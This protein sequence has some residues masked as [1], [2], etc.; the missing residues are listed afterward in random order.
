MME[1]EKAARALDLTL[2][3]NSDGSYSL[4]PVPE[5]LPGA[6]KLTVGSQVCELVE[7][8]GTLFV[9]LDDLVEPCH[10]RVTR[11]PSLNSIDVSVVSAPIPSAVPEESPGESAAT[12]A[13]TYSNPEI[14]WS[15][16]VPNGWLLVDN[17]A[18]LD[19][20]MAMGTEAVATQAGKQ[21][22]KASRVGLQMVMVKTTQTS[23]SLS[24]AT[25]AL[26]SSDLDSRT[27][28][29]LARKNLPA[30]IKDVKV[31][32]GPIP[33]RVIDGVEFAVVEYQM[34]VEAVTKRMRVLCCVDPGRQ[35]GYV[36]TLSG[37]SDME[38]RETEKVLSGVRVA[39]KA[40]VSLAD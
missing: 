3:K 29:E 8:N 28:A 30:L 17:P 31:T 25:E 21:A 38:L 20:V 15:I 12:P 7:R 23:C 16:G 32:N 13:K 18:K 19:Q 36:L 40:R 33:I 39:L 1:L 9:S 6:G 22:M 34:K 11:N 27:Y 4:G 37:K 14:G 35:L 24:L 5:N 10:L 2:S 26:P